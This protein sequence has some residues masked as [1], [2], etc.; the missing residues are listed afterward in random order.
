MN[1]VKCTNTH[2]VVFYVYVKQWK[3]FFTLFHSSTTAEHFQFKRTS[4]TKHFFNEAKVC[5]QYCGNL[6]WF[7][8]MELCRKVQK[9]HEKKI[10][11]YLEEKNDGIWGCFFILSIANLCGN[12][13]LISLFLI[14]KRKKMGL[15]NY[16]CLQ[17]LCVN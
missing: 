12:E 10:I 15:K 7:F 9:I 16:N 17:M 1:P 3:C 2:H 8:K 5:L 6:G 14:W 13:S 11:K 4:L